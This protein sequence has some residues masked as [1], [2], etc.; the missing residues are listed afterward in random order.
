[1]HKSYL[2]SFYYVASTMPS[3]SHSFFINLKHCAIAMLYNKWKNWGLPK[4]KQTAQGHTICN[5]RSRIQRFYISLRSLSLI[6]S[7]LQSDKGQ[8]GSQCW[9]GAVTV[10]EV[11]LHIYFKFWLYQWFYFQIRKKL[12]IKFSNSICSFV[13]DCMT[14]LTVLYFF[15]STIMKNTCSYRII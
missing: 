14:C 15:K 2:Y 6:F 4:I 7:K 3:I 5:Q 10:M 1:M 11:I 13:I 9:N 8:R 12:D